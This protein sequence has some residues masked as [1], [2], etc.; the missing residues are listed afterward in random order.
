MAD[1]LS[2]HPDNSERAGDLIDDATA[3]IGMDELWSGQL[4]YT[5]I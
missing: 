3:L 2:D 1:N 5:S 4:L